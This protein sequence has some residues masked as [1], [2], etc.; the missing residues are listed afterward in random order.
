MDNP[1]RGQ[2]GHSCSSP[3]LT[4]PPALCLAALRREDPSETNQA[5]PAIGLSCEL[6]LLHS[7]SG[8]GKA[9]GLRH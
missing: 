7:G 9:R 2:D 8:T 1:T 5:K 6:S 3:R 4:N